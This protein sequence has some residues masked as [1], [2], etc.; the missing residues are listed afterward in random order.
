MLIETFA[1]WPNKGQA[2]LAIAGSN[3]T[4]VDTVSTAGRSRAYVATSVDFPAPV[5]PTTSRHGGSAATGP[6]SWHR[7]ISATM[8]CHR[9]YVTRM[10][11]TC[12]RSAGLTVVAAAFRVIIAL[13]LPS[14]PPVTL[15]VA[16]WGVR[17]APP[18]LRQRCRDVP[19]CR[20]LLL[21]RLRVPVLYAGGARH[22]GGRRRLYAH[23]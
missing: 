23:P 1:I 17:H 8:R 5:G 19:H 10:P 12:T 21:D 22:G 9:G 11:S 20:L 4:G 16:G 2:K 18:W 14:P 6:H 15:R 7:S 13:S 3:L